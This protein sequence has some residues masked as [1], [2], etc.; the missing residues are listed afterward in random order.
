MEEKSV[1]IKHRVKLASVWSWSA[2][3]RAWR[4]SLP[5]TLMAAGAALLGESS[6]ASTPWTIGLAGGLC[7]G[8][9][10]DTLWTRGRDA[11]RYEM[12]RMFMDAASNSGVIKFKTSLHPAQQVWLEQATKLTALLDERA[13]AIE[14]MIGDAHNA[15]SVDGGEHADR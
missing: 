13:K 12:V 10:A 7:F 5:V 3:V 14:M 1:T 8:W 9:A 4:F 6:S 15:R 11:G 2:V